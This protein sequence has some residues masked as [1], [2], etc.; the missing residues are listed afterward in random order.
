MHIKEEALHD[1]SNISV[2]GKIRRIRPY[3]G[4]Q[5]T[6][7]LTYKVVDVTLNYNNTIKYLSIFANGGN[8][9]KIFPDFFHS[10]SILSI[11]SL[12]E[13]EQYLDTLVVGENR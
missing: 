11:Y 5:I 1:R 9:L 6:Q 2:G 7:G 12:T 13:D 3:A 8:R 4:S 10:Y